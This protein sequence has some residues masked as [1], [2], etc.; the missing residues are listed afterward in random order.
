MNA[1]T[2]AWTAP[3]FRRL[4]TAWVFTNLGDSALYLMVAVWVKELTGSDVAAAFVFVSL[5]VPAILAPFL[6]MVADRVSRKALMIVTNAALVPL[7]LTLMFMTDPNGVW[8]AYAVILVY[9]SGGY[10]TAAAQS[11]IIRGML[12][13]EQL[14]SGNGVLS[15]IDNGLRLV[16]P[17]V[18]TAL[19]VWIGPN[20]VVM[21]TAACFAI[22]AI[23]F[24][25][26]PTLPKPGEQGSSR[27]YLRELVAGFE[28]LGR[29]APLRWVTLA[30]AIAF[31]A[32]GLLNVLVFPILEGMQVAPATIGWLVPVQGAGA[33]LGGLVSAAVVRRLGEP[34]TAALGMGLLGLGTLP[35]ITGSLP[36]AVAGMVVVGFGIPL[37]VVAYATQRQRLTPDALQGRA[38]AA[39]NVAINVPQTLVSIIGAGL[40]AAVDYRI[41]LAVTAAVV[42]AGGVL[43]LRARVVA[44]HAEPDA[45]DV[46]A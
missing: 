28:H 7:V 5:G 13:N 6:G 25:G 36:L 45:V 12:R 20:A 43:A 11:G 34:R 26:L 37:T 27:G 38:S 33:V 16:S 2:S 14:A 46:R 9:G 3:G 41:P 39:A 42:L 8:I 35:L 31:G 15:T 18:G 21:M 30:I 29:V 23:V 24:A 4:S 1:T 17:L 22:A 10:L 44:A 19:Y 40:I 32:T